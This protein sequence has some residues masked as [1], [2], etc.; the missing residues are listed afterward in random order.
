M[1]VLMP[2]GNVQ[3]FDIGGKGMRSLKWGAGLSLVLMACSTQAQQSARVSA[4]CRREIVKQCGVSFDRRKMARCVSGKVDELSDGCRK[5]LVERIVQKMLPVPGQR[6]IAY[7]SDPKQRLDF[8][9]PKNTK[10]PVPL[11]VYIH[12]GGW[13]IGD[14]RYGSAT[15]ANHFT[16]LGY[17]YASLNYR[18]VPSATVEQQAADVAAALANLRAN[19]RSLGIDPNRIV[20]MGHSA[21]AH[22]A[23]LVASDPAYLDA[24]RMPIAAIK[25]VIL[26]DGAAYDVAR[27]IADPRNKLPSMYK[28]A[29]GEDPKRQAALSPITHAA[30]S[31]V[32]DWLILPVAD[33]PDSSQ[34]S[35]A[36]A[37][38]LR[39]AGTR[40]T[41]TP[42]QNSS[43]GKLNRDL[44]APA[45]FATAQ[46]DD[47]LRRVAEGR[48]LSGR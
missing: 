17:A 7:G 34:Q 43:H 26:L 31:N 9:A 42:I 35:Q 32:S 24:A 10:G 16:E 20:I 25:G 33:R 13:S 48:A 44:G 14:K 27:Q 41:V 39:M 46:V 29:F 1:S 18:L 37:T 11:V 5:E 45:D 4:E 30:G 2:G 40:V 38:S 12:G 36:L 6:E 22:L 28:A 47:F 21:G 8:V 23:A 3:H 19:A 15:K